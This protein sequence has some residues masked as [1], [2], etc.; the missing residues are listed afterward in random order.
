MAEEN[1][2]Q[3]KKMEE[4][5]HPHTEKH[6]H[7]PTEKKE[8]KKTETK[9]KKEKKSEKPKKHE[10]I[11]HGR[12]LPISK[13]HGMYL[14]AFIKGKKID[15]A[16]SDLQEVLKF[17]KAVPF[18]GEI[19]HRKGKGMMSGR[20]PI[21]A[22]K[23]F[24]ILLKGLKGNVLVNGMDLEKTIIAEASSSWASRPARRNSRRAKRSHII[25]KAR[26]IGGKI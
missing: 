4:H 10:A 5:I 18:K 15:S 17:K 11:A 1:K 12:A 9:D 24:I 16:I 3:E 13:K 2:N 8:E 26:E 23:E 22:S 14:C 25:L 20:Y 21:S 7:V 19:P 6:E